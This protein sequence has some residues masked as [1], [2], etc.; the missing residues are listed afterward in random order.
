MSIQFRIQ[1]FFHPVSIVRIGRFLYR[2]QWYSSERL[3]AYQLA[4][5]KTILEHAYLFV[6]YYQ[7]LM[8]KNKIKPNDIR[9]LDD[10]KHIPILKKRHVRDF[11]HQLKAKNAEKYRPVPC[12]TSG[13]TGQTLK[14]YRDRPSDIMEFCYYRRYWS[15]AGYSL[16]M[17]FAEF[18]AH[19]F[20]N[21]D[22][23]KH[24]H[25]QPVINR[26]LLNP[27]NLS[28]ENIDCFVKSITRFRVSFLKGSPSTLYSF[29]LLLERKKN[30]GLKIK[31][32]FA[33]GELL[34]PYQRK[35]IEEILKSQ[36]F[37]SFGH[38]EMTVAISQCEK[39]TTFIR[40]MASWKLRIWRQIGMVSSK[41]VLSGLRCIN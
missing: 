21:A 41:T 20:L 34:L 28:V 26:L 30:H 8:D 12:R 36:I 18:S 38:M 39:D 17:P 35:K 32:I 19:H 25:F 15:W 22:L 7:C 33:T 31:A 2:S 6:P 40:N 37:D 27:F 11:Y 16:G 3:K 1:D 13:T 10:L 5:L 29:A 9:T 14:F 24:S 4:R 23:K